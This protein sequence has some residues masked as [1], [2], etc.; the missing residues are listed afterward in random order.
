[1]GHTEYAR[2]TEAQRC[3]PSEI[4]ERFVRIGVIA[5]AVYMAVNAV[6]VGPIGLGRDGREAFVLDELFRDPGA[7]RSE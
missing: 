4:G 2:G 3:E 7:L 1:M 5:R 6:G